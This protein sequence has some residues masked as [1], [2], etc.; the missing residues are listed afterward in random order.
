MVVSDLT[1]ITG[2]FPQAIWF[3]EGQGLEGPVYGAADSWNGVGIFFDSFD[4]DGKVCDGIWIVYHIL[5]E[6]WCG[7]S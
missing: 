1:Y 4:N 5:V 6:N 3:T 2:L 7:V